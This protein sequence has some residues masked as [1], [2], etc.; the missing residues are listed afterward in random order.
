[1]SKTFMEMALGETVI[2]KGTFVANGVT[3][4][5][6]PNVPVSAAMTIQFGLN[7]IGGTPNGAPFVS[8]VTPS[9]PGS[10]GPEGSPGYNGSI[11]VKAGS[12][13]SSTYNFRITN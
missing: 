10:P 11:S 2:Y 12:G 6:I 5:A 7:T 8:A 1:M 3:A 9:T 13:D 4:V